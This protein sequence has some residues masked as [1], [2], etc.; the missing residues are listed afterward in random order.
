VEIN[1]VSESVEVHELDWEY[2]KLV[3]DTCGGDPEKEFEP[4]IIFVADCVYDP[5][6]INAL[7][8]VLKHF[9]TKKIPGSDSGTVPTS[10]GQ[11][12]NHFPCAYVA[13]T[14]RNPTTFEHFIKTLNEHGIKHVDVTPENKIHGLSPMLWKYDYAGTIFLTFLYCEG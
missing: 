11:Q 4:E 1:K 5:D 7:V 3:S 12:Q 8:K 9:L 2:P 6:L 13:S 14:L 10:E